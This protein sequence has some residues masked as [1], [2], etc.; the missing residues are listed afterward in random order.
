MLFLII[1]SLVFFFNFLPRHSSILAIFEVKQS[2]ALDQAIPPPKEHIPS[3]DFTFEVRISDFEKKGD[4][5][6]AYIV[7]KLITKVG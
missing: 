3:A 5:M 4:G 7:Y 1:C 2:S 6:N